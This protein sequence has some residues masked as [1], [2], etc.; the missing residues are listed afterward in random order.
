MKIDKALRINQECRRIHGWFSTE[1][2]MLFALIDEIQSDNNVTGDVFEIGS[3]HGKSTVF[4]GSMI[5]PETE[6]LCVCDLFG[7]QSNNLSSSGS[8]DLEIFNENMRL[9][10]ESG[11]ELKVFQKNSNALSSID[12]G[13]NY[14]L[15]HIDGGH[16]CDEA[17]SDLKLAANSIIDKG[18]II[19]DDPFRIEWPGVTEALIRF[20]DEYSQFHAITVGFNKLIL[21]K[22]IHSSLYLDI[23]QQAETQKVY[24]LSYPWHTKELPFINKSIL[25]FY[26]PTY[27]ENDKSNIFVKNT[28][29]RRFIKLI[30]SITRNS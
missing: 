7:D 21:V 13:S 18:V 19:L 30:K 14:R 27:L 26:L 6:K 20:L 1:A 28:I 24:G 17:L 5:S 10:Q 15:F 22:S 3:H 16:N 4:L 29:F 2:A 12:I 11:V 23:I 25:I 9:I 8:G